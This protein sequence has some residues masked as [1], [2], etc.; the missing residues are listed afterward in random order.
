MKWLGKNW[1]LLILIVVLLA[2]AT[3]GVLFKEPKVEVRIV[4]VT[5]EVPVTKIVEKKVVVTATPVLATASSSCPDKAIR[6]EPQGLLQ[7]DSSFVASIGGAGCT[8]VFEGRIWESGKGIQNRHD[9]VMIRGAQDGFRY[10][11]GNGWTIPSDWSPQEFACLLWEGKQA[12]WLEQ[13]ITPLPVKFWGF[14]P[15]PSCAAVAQPTPTPIP[16][17]K[18]WPATAAEAATIFGGPAERW[19][20][21]P[22]ENRCWHLKEGDKVTLS[23]PDYAWLEG[24]DGSYTI[25]RTNGPTSITAVGATL[26]PK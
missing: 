6:V 10:W 13:G 22:G 11:E 12:N 21:C 2:A 16:S 20:G 7:D 4:E 9:I 18:V 17:T 24:W 26:R 19:E 14:D 15:A 25:S 3:W 23:V 8:T 1:I 5:K